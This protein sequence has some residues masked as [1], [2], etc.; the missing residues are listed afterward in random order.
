[1]IAFNGGNRRPQV[2]GKLIFL[3]GGRG[4]PSTAPVLSKVEWL[5]EKN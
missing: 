4:L 1:M 3:R 2:G 5:M